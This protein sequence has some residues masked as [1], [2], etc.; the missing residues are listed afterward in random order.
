MNLEFSDMIIGKQ[1][2]KNKKSRAQLEKMA[3]EINKDLGGDS[4]NIATAVNKSKFQKP[5]YQ[6]SSSSLLSDF[7][8][9]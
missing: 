6:A 9:E 3:N 8:L 4:L 7:E 5:A 1:A 2:K